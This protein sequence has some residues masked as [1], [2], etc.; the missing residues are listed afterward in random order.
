MNGNEL[1]TLVQAV[2]DTLYQ[3][4]LP[5]L[6]NLD[7]HNQ[8]SSV[9]LDTFP[10]A[11]GLSAYQV[12]QNNG[13]VGSESQWLASLI[14]PNGLN[15]SNGLNGVNGTNGTNGINGYSVLSGTVVPASSLGSVNDL[16]IN[17]LTYDLFK[18]TAS[19]TWTLQCNLKG[20]TGVTGPQGPSGNF[21]IAHSFGAM[22]SNGYQKF[23][24]GLIMQW[25]SI[26]AGGNRN[27]TVNFPIA[28]TSAV[29]G[30]YSG[31]VNTADNATYEATIKSISL[32]QV[33]V[34]LYAGGGS[35]G[36]YLLAIG[37]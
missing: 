10:V 30:V 17:T 34:N 31:A 14:G 16:Y 37:V 8:L 32:T 18:K 7:V 27:V 6:E 2:A 20:A 12:A 21:D 5:Y 11:Q 36:C 24:N 33:G 4:I 28:F 29:F 35:I 22:N 1:K 15:G 25:V 3:N 13:F 19:A 26:P 9:V 23:S